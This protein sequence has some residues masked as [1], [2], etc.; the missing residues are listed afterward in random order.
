[1][2][3]KNQTASL[4]YKCIIAAIGVAALINQTGLLTGTF[5]VMFLY[6]FTNLS[7]VAVAAYFI[8][9]IIHLLRHCKNS[10]N[11]TEGDV[12]APQVKY[13]CTMAV[14]VTCLIAHFLLNHGGVIAADGSINLPMLALHY[15]VPIGTVLDWLL[16]DE[17]GHMKLN[18]PL[19]WVAFPLIYLAYTMIGVNVF[20]LVM[21]APTFGGRYP[22]PFI[23][24]DALGIENVAVTCVVLV[25]A[26]IAL[27]YMYVAIDHLLARRK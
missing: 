5:N 6:F 20:G 16:F 21:S 1:M 14:T 22:Y 15:L 9:A 25:A 7:N 23:D 8:G 26:F 18:G 2:R 11:A 19:M 10:N 4:V 24:I 27:V 3:I 13:A 17:K 12:W